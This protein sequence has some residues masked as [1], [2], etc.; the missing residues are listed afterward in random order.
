MLSD[1]ERS[2][3]WYDTV[4]RRAP[5]TTEN[6][7][8]YSAALERAVLERA[9]IAAWLFYADVCKKNLLNPHHHGEWIASDA[10]RA[11]LPKEES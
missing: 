3:L 2:N 11:L 5:L 7:M 1:E 6:I 8:K 9:A 10:I 4:G